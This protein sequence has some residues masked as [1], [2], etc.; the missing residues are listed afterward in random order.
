M[1]TILTLWYQ[2]A[3]AISVCNRCIHKLMF[4]IGSRRESYPHH[5]V[6]WRF[7]LV[8]SSKSLFDKWLYRP[9]TIGDQQS[10]TMVLWGIFVT[11]VFQKLSCNKQPSHI[12]S[13]I[14]GFCFSNLSIDDRCTGVEIP[15][16][17]RFIQ[18]RSFSN[19]IGKR[20]YTKNRYSTPEGAS[21]RCPRTHKLRSYL[22]M[23]E[24]GWPV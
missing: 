13:D 21:S 4:R 7:A 23:R 16:I 10:S 20:K 15:G 17:C 1:L 3:P 9:R 18:F 14:S 11:H 6:A 8:K 5:L 12:G 24:A 2:R 19:C 22:I